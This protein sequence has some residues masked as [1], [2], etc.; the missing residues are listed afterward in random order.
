MSLLPL[1]SATGS[2]FNLSATKIPPAQRSC[3][4]K[5]TLNPGTPPFTFWQR[6]AGLTLS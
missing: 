2:T 1:W 3:A 4:L 6:T 5:H